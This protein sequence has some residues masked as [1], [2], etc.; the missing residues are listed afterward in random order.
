MAHAYD[1]YNLASE[2]PVVDGKLSLTCH[3]LAVDACY[4]HFCQK[5]EKFEGKQFAVDADYF[6]FHLQQARTEELCSPIV[7]RLPEKRKLD[8]ASKEKLAPFS[9]LSGDERYQSCDLEKASQQVAKPLYDAKVQPTTL[10]PKLVGNTY[11]ASLYAAF[12]S[13]LHNKNSS[14]GGQRAVLFS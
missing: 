1:F 10:I 6:V 12:A 3:L 11:T 2:Y 4:K 14:L 13:L 7:Q 8:E 5:Y 9:N